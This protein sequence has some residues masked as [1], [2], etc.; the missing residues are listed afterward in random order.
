ME[1]KFILKK[2]QM[3]EFRLLNEY[4]Q[5]KKNCKKVKKSKK[6]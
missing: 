3:K 6:K 2:D 4:I 5:I 1:K